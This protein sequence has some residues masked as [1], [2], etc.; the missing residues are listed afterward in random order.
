[1]RQKRRRIKAVERRGI[2]YDNNLDCRVQNRLTTAAAE[3]RR[4]Q[5]TVEFII[6]IIIKAM[7]LTW[8][9]CKSTARPRYNRRG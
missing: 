7:R 1:M 5:C 2:T 3:K 9:K 6:I 4:D 8:Y